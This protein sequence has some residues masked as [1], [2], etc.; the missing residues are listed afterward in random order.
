MSDITTLCL[1]CGQPKTEDQY[2][3]GRHVCALCAG[4][5]VYDAVDLARST[6]ARLESAKKMV[7]QSA[8]DRR[9][10]ARLAQ[11]GKEGK[12]CSACHHHKPLT[13]YNHCAPAADGLQPNCR[14]CDKLRV[15]IMNSAPPGTGM[16]TWHTVRDSLRAQA[17][18]NQA[19]RK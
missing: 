2:N 6:V 19:D 7:K 3:I 9:R 1:C 4:L 14:A 8:A 11:Y 13:D 15:S 17:A 16:S 10:L 12:R 18:A 5:S